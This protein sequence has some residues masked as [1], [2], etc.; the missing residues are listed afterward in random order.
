MAIRFL[1]LAC[2]CLTMATPSMAQH[3][4]SAPDSVLPKDSRSDASPVSA[5]VRRQVA[6]SPSRVLLSAGPTVGTTGLGL[7][8]GLLIGRPDRRSLFGFHALGSRGFLADTLPSSIAAFHLVAARALPSSSG[9]LTIVLMGGIGGAT[10]SKK[11]RLVRTDTT[12]DAW[13]NGLIEVTS[14]RPIYK[15]KSESSPSALLGV[16]VGR[17]FPKG[18]GLSFFTGVVACAQPTFLLSLQVHRADF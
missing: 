2:L 18:S 8:G 10:T 15:K 9:P 11:G 13:I 7:Q 5:S 3:L 14:T 17:A 1:I 6:P 12:T 4:E 16:Q